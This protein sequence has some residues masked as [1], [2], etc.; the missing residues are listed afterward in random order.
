MGVAR[1]DTS[2][3]SVKSRMEE[4][5]DDDRR[6]LR[7][8]WSFTKD[9][10]IDD[11]VVIANFGSDKD[12]EQCKMAERWLDKL[13]GAGQMVKEE[14]MCESFKEEEGLEAKIHNMLS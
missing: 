4:V 7:M 12:K 8:E 6:I 9:F 13:E 3:H 5:P 10:N 14:E 1:W 2:E 11:K